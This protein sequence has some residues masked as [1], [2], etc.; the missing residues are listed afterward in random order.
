M[1]LPGR[2]TYVLGYPTSFLSCPRLRPRL[3]IAAKAPGLL[4]ACTAGRPQVECRR[5]T[6]APATYNDFFG[7][8]KRSSPPPRLRPQRLNLRA[9]K[10]LSTSPRIATSL[11]TNDRSSVRFIRRTEVPSR[12]CGSARTMKRIRPLGRRDRVQSHALREPGRSPRDLQLDSVSRRTFPEPRLSLS[13]LRTAAIGP[14][15][16]VSRR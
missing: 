11:I 12:C 9:N 4:H 1:S 7:G 16:V 14:L 13:L 2:G 8:S 6:L 5:L 15:F 3:G 10:I